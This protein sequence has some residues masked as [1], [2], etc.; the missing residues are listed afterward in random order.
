MCVSINAV[1]TEVVRQS[2]HHH[3]KGLREEWLPAREQALA[4]ERTHDRS[5]A[6]ESLQRA[7]G[8]IDERDSAV[9]SK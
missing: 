1:G 2:L 3:A 7:R 8:F 9:Q 5:D 6:A 4:D